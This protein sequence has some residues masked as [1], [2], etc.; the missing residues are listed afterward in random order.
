MVCSADAECGGMFGA[1]LFW[2]SVD[3]DARADPEATKMHDHRLRLTSGD[4]VHRR[5][6]VRCCRP[7]EPSSMHLGRW[8]RPVSPA[9]VR[10]GTPLAFADQKR[11]HR[12]DLEHQSWH[13]EIVGKSL[14]AH[15]QG[16]IHIM[17]ASCCPHARRWG[18]ASDLPTLSSIPCNRRPRPQPFECPKSLSSTSLLLFLCYP[19]SY[20]IEPA[21][22]SFDTSVPIRAVP[23]CS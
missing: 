20:S 23:T 11:A 22:S 4:S 10:P 16:P 5:G 9:A 6:G 1:L 15:N 7:N 12:S 17:G 8:S 14:T 13:L 18:A 2:L 21:A 3:D 19:V